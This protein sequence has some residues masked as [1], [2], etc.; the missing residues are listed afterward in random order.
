VPLSAIAINCT[1]KTSGGEPSSTDKMIGV[2][3]GELQKCGVEV[4]ETIRIA[5]H[6]IKPGVTSDEGDGDAWPGIRK[7]ILECDIL[8][9]GTPIWLGQ[10]SSLAK[11]VL[12]RMDAFFS[13]T[14]DAGR[15]PSFNHVAV[16]G[17]VGN[18]D[19][20]HHV[21]AELLQALND[22][23]WTIPAQAACYWVGEAMHKTD[24][25]DLPQVP[26]NVHGLAGILAANAVHVANLLR[27][28]P[29]PGVPKQK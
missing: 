1:L 24:F 12:E 26:D 14:D 16:V 25:K 7:R 17:I 2:I 20:A 9:F 21:T 6:D 27:G 23:G 22:T 18:E 11:R 3:A 10:P 5:D 13:E 15:M 29:Y 28:Q 8:V 19:G 4:R